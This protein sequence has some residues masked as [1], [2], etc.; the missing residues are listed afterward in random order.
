MT[1]KASHTVEPVGSEHWDALDALFGRA[2]ASNGCWCQYWILGPAYHRRDRALNRTALRSE[3]VKGTPPAPGLVA[4]GPDHQV[5]GWAR[6]VPRGQLRW[7]EARFSTGAATG[8][9]WAMPC[10]FIRPAARGT[11]VMS[12]LVEAAI[13]QATRIGATVEAY[14]IDPDVPGATRNRFTGVL[15]PFLR[16][17]FDE[18]GRLSSGRCV[19]RH[20]PT[21]GR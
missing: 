15:E 8:D 14:P 1:A 11:G 21:P 18:V 4:F 12:S 2:G 13:S 7:P 20:F 3:C 10:F 9:L 16:A 17:G 19:V 6:L 5:E